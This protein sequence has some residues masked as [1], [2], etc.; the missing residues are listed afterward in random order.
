[1][2]PLTVLVGMTTE[3]LE[4]LAEQLGE[5]RYRGRQLAR[6]VY[7]KC[8]L[9]FDAMT[10]LPKGL[11]ERLS[12]T[13]IVN[14]IAVVDV[15]V[16]SDG[17]TKYLGQLPDGETVEFVFIP[18]GNW[19]TICVST[20]V[21]CPIGCRFCASG[22]SY[23]R[24]LTAGEIVAQVLIAKR[25]DNPNIVFMGMGEPFLN[26]DNLIKALRL[27][28]AEGGIGV[29]RMTV[30]TVGLVNG[31]RKLAR[32]GLQVNLAVSLHAPNDELRRQLIPAKLPPLAELLQACQEY[33]QATKRRVT[34]EYVLLRGVNDRPEHAVEL[35]RLLRRLPCHVNLIPYNPTTANFARPTDKDIER[36][37]RILVEH[38]IPATVR[39]ERGTEVQGA[40]G[41]LH[42]HRWQLQDRNAVWNNGVGSEGGSPEPPENGTKPVRAHQERAL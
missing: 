19:D 2:Q 29:R 39:H 28:N 38:G 25:R 21:G 22:E 13:A 42:R 8:V 5:P 32:S 16:A 40:C 27:L 33:F 26:F 24:N 18:H 41:Q 23:A 6:W 34:F 20:Q 14:P 15:K 3:E 11:R 37:R 4:A 9:T 17:T 31:I 30:S 1:M 7:R 36:F 35:A 12:A 10:D